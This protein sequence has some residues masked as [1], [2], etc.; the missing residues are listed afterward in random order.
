M[1]EIRFLTAIKN[2]MGLR[3]YIVSSVCSHLFDFIHSPVEFESDDVQAAFAQDVRQALYQS[4]NPLDSLVY[5]RSKGWVHDPSVHQA[6]ENGHNKITEALEK[7]CAE[8]FRTI[9]YDGPVSD[10][11]VVSISGSEHAAVQIGELIPEG[12]FMSVPLKG[13]LL[14]RDDGGG[15]HPR[16]TSWLQIDAVVRR[17]EDEHGIED[18]KQDFTKYWR[19]ANFGEGPYQREYLSHFLCN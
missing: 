17:F 6:M 10:P 15:I 2:D 13:G 18:M 5:L 9:G 7:V 16:K 1:T 4:R 12:C 14:V 8:R 3:R 19:K 11:S